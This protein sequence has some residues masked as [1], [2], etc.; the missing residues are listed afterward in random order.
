MVRWSHPATP[1]VS[2]TDRQDLGRWRTVLEIAGSGSRSTGCVARIVQL[3]V[4]VS[5]LNWARVSFVSMVFERLL[6]SAGSH[7]DLYAWRSPKVPPLMP[8][9][10]H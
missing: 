3:N 4:N 8:L 5:P 7:R 1:S 2:S 9:V 10:P 6:R